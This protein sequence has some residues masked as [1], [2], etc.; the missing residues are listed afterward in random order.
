MLEKLF[1]LKENNT[2]V[3]TELIA[4]LITFLTMAYVLIVNPSILGH[5]G[6]QEDALFTATA[7]AAI[8]GTF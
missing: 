4:G 5:T 3:K 6:M 2:N 8:I 7:V 1:K